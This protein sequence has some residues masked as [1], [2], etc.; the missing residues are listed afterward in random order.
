MEPPEDARA[1]WN[2]KHGDALRSGAAPTGPSSFLTA[3]E[4]LLPTSGRAVDVAGGTGRHALWLARRGLDVTLVDV[5]DTACA[6]ATRRAIDTGVG[7]D[8]VRA[9]LSHEPPPAGPWDVIVV[10]HW[11]DREVWARLPEHLAPQGLLLLCQATASNAERHGRPLATSC[12][13]TAR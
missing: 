6:E 11:L 5:S 10:A 4:A 13:T 8:V 9:D 7:L 3:N 2:R 1:R 12:S